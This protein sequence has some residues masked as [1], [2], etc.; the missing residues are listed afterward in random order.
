MKTTRPISTAVIAA[1]ICVRKN[2]EV[3]IAVREKENSEL[4][5]LTGRVSPLEIVADTRETFRVRDEIT[6]PQSRGNLYKIVWSDISLK[7]ISTK[8]LDHMI[9]VGGELYIFMYYITDDK[10]APIQWHAGTVSFSGNIE[11][12]DATE[13]MISYVNV[14][15][16]ES[17]LS[18]L[19]NDM[20]E[21]EEVKMVRL[22]RETNF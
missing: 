13:D 5:T 16:R 18:P 19:E 17:S 8:L 3:E 6:V 7:S 10:E 2:R 14:S 11:M 20:G 1:M 9:H 21:C 15:I 22:S 4:C 12:Q